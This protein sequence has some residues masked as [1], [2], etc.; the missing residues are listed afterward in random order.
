MAG[1][2]RLMQAIRLRD[3]TQPFDRLVRFNWSGQFVVTFAGMLASFFIVGF[4]YPFWR[5]SSSSRC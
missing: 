4:W 2:S 3:T 1:V 5:V